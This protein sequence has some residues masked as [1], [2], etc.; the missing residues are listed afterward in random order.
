MHD[1][2]GQDEVA[3]CLHPV[4]VSREGVKDPGAKG[5]ETLKKEIQAV[6]RSACRLY[7]RG[8]IPGA[9]GNR[10]WERPVSWY[11]WYHR[12]FQF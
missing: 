5:V 2:L 8:S 7:R 11:R 10:Q 9:R 12:R 1:L 6:N 4:L 3:K